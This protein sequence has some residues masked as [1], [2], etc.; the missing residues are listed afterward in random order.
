MKG[1]SIRIYKENFIFDIYYDDGLG[2]THVYDHGITDIQ[3]YEFFSS[4]MYLERKRKDGSFVAVG[5][6]SD[7]S[8]K[9][10]FRKVKITKSLKWFFIISAWKQAL[11]EDEI[12]DIRSMEEL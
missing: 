11:S 4:E 3:I 10:I 6:A 2:N 1:K 9:V 5:Y 7:F 12:D 8:L